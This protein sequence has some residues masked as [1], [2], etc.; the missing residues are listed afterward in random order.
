MRAATSIVRS[1]YAEKIEGLKGSSF[2]FFFFGGGGLR[3]IE[4]DARVPAL[5]WIRYDKL[6]ADYSVGYGRQGLRRATAASKVRFA[7]MAERSGIQSL[8]F[9]FP[10]LSAGEPSGAVCGMGALR[11]GAPREREAQLATEP[12]ILALAAG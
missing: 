5:G 9:T 7:A 10:F 1:C 3:S 6:H 4:C 8:L 12:S 11:V 2:C